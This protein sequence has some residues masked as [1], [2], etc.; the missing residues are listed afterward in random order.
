VGSSGPDVLQLQQRLTALGYWSGPLDGSF[1]GVTEQAVFA[2]QK[3]A[4]LSP[5]GTVNAA[6]RA[7]LTNGTRPRARSTSGRFIEVDLFDF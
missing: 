7:A 2:L 6:T 1:G 5:S 3:A 4:G